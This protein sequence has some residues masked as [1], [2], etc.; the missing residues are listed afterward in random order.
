MRAWLYLCALLAAAPARADCPRAAKAVPIAHGPVTVDGVLDDA[1]WASACFVDDF[2]QKTPAFGAAPTHRVIAAV[3]TDG[4]T[5]Y[6][7]ARMWSAGVGEID[8]ALTQ[9]DDTQ[10]AERFIVSID[11]SHTRRVAYSFA[12][13]AAGV[14][15][16]W[17]H[18]DD[19]ES[20]RD[21]TWNPVWR[22]QARI[23]ADG[24]TAELAMPL[25]QLRLPATPQASW[26]I[27][28]NWYIPH[29]NEDVF[30]RAVPPDRTAWA[31]WFGELTELP[32]IERGMGLELL[33]YAASRLTF[34]E[35]PTGALSHRTAIGVDAGLDAKFRPLR[36][37]TVAATINP[38]FGQVDVDPAVVNLT[39]FEIQL[40]E[41]RPFFIENAPLFVNAGGAYFYSRRIGGLPRT[42][43]T[44]D[45]IALP[46]Q[47]RILG[48][49]AAGGFIADRTQIAVLGAVTN[50][51]DADA[52]IGVDRRRLAVAPL[53]GW[54]AARVERQTGSSVLGATATAVTRDLS[55]SPLAQLL[56]RTALVGGGDA[57][58][59]TADGTYDLLVFGG[60]SSVFGTPEAISMVEQSSTHYFQR[61]DASH[62]HLDTTA[63]SLVGWHAGAT[64]SKRAGAWQ[65]NAL[66]NVESPGFEL[67]DLGVL[68]SADDIDVSTDL[69]HSVTRPGERVFAWNAGG[70]AST[71]WNFG[72]MHKPIDLRASGDV[73]STAFN[74]A[75]IALD[76]T[77]PGGSDDA[78][79]GGPVME[80]DWI[81]S[82]KLTASTP[83]GRARQLSGSLLAQRSASLP[84]GVV[85]SLSASARVT[86][87][88]RIDLAPSVTWLDNRRQYVATVT[89]AGAK[90]YVFGELHRKEAALELRATWS[91]SPDLV[92]T[93]YAQPF[94]SVGRYSR[95]G[96]LATAGSGDVR[97]Y[98]ATS[99]EATMRRIVDGSSGFTIDEPD[100][101]IASLR[102]TAVLRWE[103]RPGSTL[104]V[105][106]QQSRQGSDDV[107]RPLHALTPDV[108]T[109]PGIHSLALKLSYWFG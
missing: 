78:T 68:Q 93:L 82:V 55:G 101:S 25:S 32:R 91:L 60:A 23:L 10:G 96:E 53:T 13:T 11:P 87:A 15:A 100:F 75:S 4:D 1:T 69:R 92:L 79:R 81:E 73:T 51:A 48:A 65:G 74:T 102:S 6:I 54:A 106:W 14:R 19:T 40:T 64:G 95:L 52:I 37:L 45:E 35:S 22:A 88:L 17:I 76:V 56:P 84:Q 109:R 5:L 85:A 47:V 99:H 46:T 90:R 8:D 107:S 12:V 70:G 86:P 89:D 98:D 80:T 30:W 58:L 97:W 104:F 44:A 105:V 77:T 43:P 67:N 62:L 57:R 103:L 41:K 18:T 108:V 24:W 49:V 27:N 31:S 72:G 26:G 33:P 63:R 3:A 61:P 50:A 94:V 9:R 21:A 20:A 59:R 83:R 34:D 36:G 29:S 71:S 7:A 66:V 16:D 28:F 38:D 42:L 2:E 39:A